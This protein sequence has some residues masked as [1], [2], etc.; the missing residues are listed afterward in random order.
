MALQRSRRPPARRLLP[1]SHIIRLFL[2]L[3]I[4]SRLLYAPAISVH[5]PHPAFHDPTTIPSTTDKASRRSSEREDQ[6]ACSKALAV[7]LIGLVVLSA[8]A[9]SAT[10]TG[11]E[12][13]YCQCIKRCRTVPGT[14][15]FDCS[16]AC[17]AG[18]ISGGHEGA[19]ESCNP[20]KL[21]PVTSGG[22]P[23]QP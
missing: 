5:P 12:S 19:D 15:H 2:A 7:I 21:G 10:A 20:D 16:K 6:M 11:D 18:C 22:A 23:R 4:T 13:C 8:S 1:A 9:S 14:G 17:E 3:D